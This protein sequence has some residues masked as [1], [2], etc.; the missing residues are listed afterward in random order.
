MTPATT[1]PVFV[2]FF[3]AEL[4][5]EAGEE[6]EVEVGNAVWMIVDPDCVIVKTGFLPV[7]SGPAVAEP[8]AGVVAVAPP[9]EPPPMTD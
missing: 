1:A 3:V 9:A 5:V 7:A 4:E 8:A 6:E 2:L